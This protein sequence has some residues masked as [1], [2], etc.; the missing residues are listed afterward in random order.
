MSKPFNPLLGET[1]EL[2]MDGDAPFHYISEQVSHHPPISALYVQGKNWTLSS[3]VEPKVKFHGTNV[4]AISEGRWIL[5]IK[6]KILLSRSTSQS[7]FQSCTEEENDEINNETDIEDEYIWKTPSVVV[8]NILF[9]RLWCEFQGQIDITHTQSNHHSLLTFK[10]HSW[11]SSKTSD[12]FKYM[13]FIYN[14]KDKLSAYHGNYG[15][16]YYAVDDINDID[17]KTTSRCEAGGTNCIHLNMNETKPSPCDLFLTPSS[18][19]IWHRHF[20]P[21]TDEEIELR[22]KYYLF[23]PFTMCL[24]E[25]APSSAVLPL[26]DC[27]YRLDIRYLEKGDVDGASA[28]KHRLEEQQRAEARE[29]EGEFEPLWFKKDDNGEYVYN[30]QYEEKNFYRSPNLFSKPFST[31]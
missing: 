25:E 18:R 29:R 31:E 28:E 2:K 14:G 11:F 16:C 8:H 6:K 10:S 4:I 27:R 24:N 20:L 30:D 22:S 17:I 26:T 1:Y 3:N 21:M 12:M 7:S 9:G 23:T 13:G 15:H 19:L 5:R